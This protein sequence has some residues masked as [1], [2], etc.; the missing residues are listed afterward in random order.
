MYW[1]MSNSSQCGVGQTE[2]GQ[3]KQ[4]KKVLQ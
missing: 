2:S 4:N 1:E 3:S